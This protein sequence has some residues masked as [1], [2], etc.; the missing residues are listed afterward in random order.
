MNSALPS[1]KLPGKVLQEEILQKVRQAYRPEL[2]VGPGLG[3]DCAVLKCGSGYCVASMDPITGATSDAGTLAVQVTANDIAACGVEPMAIMMTILVPPG[4]TTSQISE[5][6]QQATTAARQLNLA[7]A[8][9]HTE[10]TSA[11][12]RPVVVTTGI[13]YTEE[14][15]LGSVAIRPGDSLCMTKSIAME[16]TAILAADF[17]PK[18]RGLGISDETIMGGR[19]LAEHVSVVRDGLLAREYGA[20]AMH[21]ATEGGIWGAIEEMCSVA[22]CGARVWQERVPLRQESSIICKALEVDPYCLLSSGSMLVVIRQDAEGFVRLMR[23]A[24][25]ETTHIG[26][27]V[28]G[29]SR[30]ILKNGEEIPL[31]GPPRDEIYRILEILANEEAVENA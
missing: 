15:M 13:G 20:I 6:A 16:G 26:E 10:V 17:A 9:G 22:G 8:G 24:E 12:T 3:L 27:F 21:D 31:A 23:E 25:I 30:V 29:E 4:T 18:L 19:D 5:I 28:Q 7:I 1:G 11:V 2:V 14:I